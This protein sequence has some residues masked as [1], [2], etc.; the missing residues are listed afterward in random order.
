MNKRKEDET[1]KTKELCENGCNITEKDGKLILQASNGNSKQTTYYAS[2]VPGSST[3]GGGTSVLQG[4]GN[5]LTTG[6]SEWSNEGALQHH[7]EG[8]QELKERFGTEGGCESEGSCYNTEYA[9][10]YSQLTGTLGAVSPSNLVVN[11]TSR[12]ATVYTVRQASR[13]R[14]SADD[15]VGTDALS[16]KGYR[17]LLKSIAANGLQNNRIEYVV[18]DNI[19]HVT[20][21]SN[22]LAAARE[23][24]I[25]NQL[26]FVEVTLPRANYI[27]P[28]DLQRVAP[29]RNMG[30]PVRMQN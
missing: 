27:R 18:R 23:L 11:S 9:G 12:A 29:P 15:Y 3:S 28:S 19:P 21:G 24:G 7:Y 5:L 1:E 22:R 2:S 4:V 8:Y 30:P 10:M 13:T 25:T 14:F 17:K 20:L 26:R 6:F 16:P